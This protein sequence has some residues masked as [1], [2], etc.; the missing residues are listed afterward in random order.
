MRNILKIFDGDNWFRYLLDD[1][2]D[3]LVLYIPDYCP[4]VF[5]KYPE[6]TLAIKKFNPQ[7]PEILY[8]ITFNCGDYLACSKFK[9]E[10]D[11]YNQY[12]SFP[13]PADFGKIDMQVTLTPTKNGGVDLDYTGSQGVLYGPTKELR[14]DLVD[15][16]NENNLVGR[17]TKNFVTMARDSFVGEKKEYDIYLGAEV[18]IVGGDDVY[19][20][21]SYNKEDPKN[22]I[23]VPVDN[24]GEIKFK[25]NDSKNPI[26]FDSNK[27]YIEGLHL[28]AIIHFIFKEDDLDLNV[29]I[30]SNP[31][32][33][34]PQKFA[35]MISAKT[36]KHQIDIPE[37]MEINN[38]RI[39][40]KTEQKVVEMTSRSD[41]KS[42][43]IQPVF[44]RVRE[45]AQII[46]HPE[47]SEAICINLDSY[48]SQCERF[49]VKI[50]GVS[51]AEIGRTESG[52]I[53]R[54]QGNLLPGSQSFGTYY[55]L[56]ENA[57]LV[58]T[59]RYVYEY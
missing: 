20:L 44:F 54:I 5:N 56:N 35:E 59:G 37:N 31:F 40:S 3:D 42:N 45:L 43:I 25:L 58:T 15:F 16:D 2:G 21:S 28:V 14:I 7:E 19:W 4:E 26:P 1:D 23:Y 52:V 27:D 22:P 51:F 9:F 13:K 47:V 50:E 49:Y 12:I 24:S 36:Y 48:K 33:L 53:F 55:I 39:A 10:L 32:A 18:A 6:L 57:D 38:I 11:T 34:T 17:V 41:S 30:K 46:V 8:T 29:D